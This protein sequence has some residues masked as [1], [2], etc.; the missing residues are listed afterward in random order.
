MSKEISELKLEESVNKA[1][2][3][4]NNGIEFSKKSIKEMVIVLNENVIISYFNQ[5]D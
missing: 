4:F 1:V 3:V 2:Y 5:I